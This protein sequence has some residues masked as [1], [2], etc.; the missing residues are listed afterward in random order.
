MYNFN[1]QNQK[2]ISKYGQNISTS[3]LPNIINIKISSP[4]NS[5][6]QLIL[7]SS[8]SSIGHI[9]RPVDEHTVF[10]SVSCDGFGYCNQRHVS[11][12]YMCYGMR[13]RFEGSGGE[14]EGCCVEMMDCQLRKHHP[15][16]LKQS[17]GKCS[18]FNEV[19]GVSYLSKGRFAGDVGRW[20]D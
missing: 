6:T 13:W 17:G 18:F 11:L 2:Q 16:Q 1:Q 15:T 20:I 4:C 10:I 5:W 8:I 12:W 3:Y 14:E 9:P 19:M 7:F